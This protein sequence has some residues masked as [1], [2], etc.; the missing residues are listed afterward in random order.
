[1]KFK[2][3]SIAAV[4]FAAFVMSACNSSDKPIY[5]RAE[6]PGTVDKRAFAEK[7]ES[8]SVLNLQMD[9]DWTLSYVH[10]LA[11]S[12]NYIYMIGS[13]RW[14]LMSFDRKTG[15]KL[16]GRTIK[17]NGRGEILG[18][19]PLFCIGDTLCI[20]DY[21]GIINQY[22]YK[23]HY[24]GK[25]HEFNNISPDYSLVR[26]ANG[27]YAFVPIAFNVIDTAIML[28]DKGFNITSAHFTAPKFDFHIDEA[29]PTYYV[30]GDTVRALFM[31]DCHIYTLYGNK[32]QITELV[33]P[34]PVT[35]EKS[36]DLWKT[37]EAFIDVGKHYDS[38]YCLSGAGRSIFVKATVDRKKYLSF[39]DKYTCKVV[40]APL[41]KSKKPNT[42]A[43]IVVSIFKQMD[44]FHTDGKFIYAQF[45][46]ADLAKL[47]D[48]NNILDARLKKTQATY[49]EFLKR[50]AD[51]IKGLEPEELDAAKVIL[52]I[53]LKD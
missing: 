8:I 2:H 30:E 22:D 11:F 16:A 53:K 25:L 32:E 36:N 10:K 19:H 37:N 46:N 33:V 26:L 52:K 39:I 35:P 43:D 23:T 14:I 1:M 3:L 12:D 45:R 49:R 15:Q 4:C 29:N 38:F 13:S 44:F 40:S 41:P 48:H 7:V 24:I 34:N 17:G 51:Y 28:A 6:F 5:N 42:A 31:D 18:F 20:Y 50:N 47:L 21:K 9:D 27:N